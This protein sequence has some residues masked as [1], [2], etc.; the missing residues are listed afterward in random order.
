MGFHPRDHGAADVIFAGVVSLPTQIRQQTGQQALP[1]PDV[2]AFAAAARQAQGAPRPE[3]MP[4]WGRLVA[5][6]DEQGHHSP[7]FSLVRRAA[8][9]DA[10]RAVLLASGAGS[11]HLNCVAD[12]R[13]LGD[14]RADLRPALGA[15]AETGL[16][17]Y[18]QAASVPPQDAFGAV[19]AAS[20]ARRG[21]SEADL[22]S[23]VRACGPAYGLDPAGL[24]QR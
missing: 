8:P 19:N 1:Y 9:M 10:G 11:D 6:C 16:R 24:P 12:M 18:A 20:Q 15:A 21:A 5:A 13:L 7:A 2:R 23:R 4:A 3:P 22:I 17:Q 14:V